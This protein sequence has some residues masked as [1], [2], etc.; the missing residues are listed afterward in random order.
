MISKKQLLTILLTLSISCLWAQNGLEKANR[1]Y[2]KF[3]Y[4]DAIESYERIANKGYKSVEIFQKLGNAYYFNSDFINAEKWYSE[5]FK[6]SDVVDR[7]YYYRYAQSLKSVGNYTK[8]DSYMQKFASKSNDARARLF[9][10]N[11]NY[12]DKI[13]A[14][15]GRFYIKNAAIN[16]PYSDY[17]TAILNDQLIFTS[18]RDTSGIIRRKHSWTNESFTD[19]YS[20]TIE[21]DSLRDVQKFAKKTSSKFHESTPIFTSDGTTMYFTRNNYINRKKGK[22]TKKITLLQIYKSVLK[23]TENGEERWSNPENLSFN[24]D[25]YN[26]A[27]PALS[28]DNRTLY[29]ASDMPGTIGLSDIFSVEIKEDGSFTTPKNLG[30]NINTEGRESFPFVAK[31]ELY[32]ASDGRPGLG[33]L[34]IYVAK[35]RNN[36]LSTPINI[37]TPA[38]SPQDDFAF[39]INPNTRTGFLS[40]NRDGGIG[41][42]DIYQFTEILKLICEQKLIGLVRNRLTKDVIENAK[43]TLSDNNL[44]VL[45]SALSDDKGNYIFDSIC[46]EIYFIKVEKEGFT[47]DEQSV[48][49]PNTTGETELNF[50]LEQKEQT[51][52]IGD[53]LAVVLKLNPIYFDLDKAN[54]RDDAAL[55]LQR[56]FDVMMQNPTIELNI[57]SHTDS[58]QTTEYNQVLSDARA[59]STL[60]Y[61]VK[62]GINASRLSSKGYGESALLNHCADGVQCSEEQ[63]QKNRRSE[64]IVISTL[65]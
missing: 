60:N 44:N 62:Q 46:G 9:T 64:F 65:K 4:V 25:Q 54:I 59:Q 20:A 5:L 45:S 12:Q 40:S 6:F 34:D 19:L 50:D 10:Q 39:Y 27:H 51:I 2:D 58:R 36:S 3:A 14:N 48:T 31:D 33:G 57:R 21:G 11:L 15:S 17:G 38:N 18:A 32:F 43:I 53:D 30:N 29:F 1:E 23:S 16:S 8:S 35:I 49:I 41:N 52:E 55:E 7:E 37:G 61:L 22:N 26:T 56:V 63:H 47:T 42:D 24:S 28:H 13:K